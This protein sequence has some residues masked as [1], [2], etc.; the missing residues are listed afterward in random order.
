MGA[1]LNNKSSGKAG[2]RARAYR[3]MSEINVTPFVDVMLV[4]LIIFMVAAPL[5]T[6]GVKIDLP[7]A[8]AS[9]G[10]TEQNKEP[11]ELSIRKDG[12]IYLGKNKTTKARLITLLDVESNAD[13]SR[14]IFLRADQGLAYGE[15]MEVMARI[16]KAGY[17]KVA[18]ITD[19]H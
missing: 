5:T 10:D 4:L 19:P 18:L 17:S 2:R 16:N 11:I 1:T 13:R 3:P 7:K 9:A 14:R 6:A 12:K 15:V 8:K